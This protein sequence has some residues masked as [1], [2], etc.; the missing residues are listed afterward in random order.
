QGTGRGAV[1]LTLAAAEAQC[2]PS[3]VRGNRRCSRHELARGR[4]HAEHADDL[5]H[6]PGALCLSP[7][8]LVAVERLLLLQHCREIGGR[9]RR[10]RTSSVGAGCSIYPDGCSGGSALGIA[11]NETRRVE[12]A[13][14]ST[15]ASGFGKASAV[16]PSPF[17]WTNAF[18]S[19]SSDLIVVPT[20]GASRASV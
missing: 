3:L 4:R 14:A 16:S 15:S 20:P 13:D 8:P 17:T 1:R 6:D 18:T 2:H 19:R 11:P 5:A 10:R 7:P 12:S 9:C